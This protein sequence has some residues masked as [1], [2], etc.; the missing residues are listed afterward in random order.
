MIKQL[1]TFAMMLPLIT[2]LSCKQENNTMNLEATKLFQEN[3]NYPYMAS[4]KR[5]AVILDNMNKL[6]KRMTKN[7]VI[8]LM[9]H[10]DEFNLTYKF[11]RSK[12]EDVIGFSLVYLLRRNA[13]S[14]NAI[15]KN[16]QLLRIHFDNS[17]KLLWAYSSG[18]KGFNVIK[19]E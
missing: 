10:P 9:T 19:K 7:Q 17:E 18:I 3:I 1:T 5:K 14:G 13:K 6:E 4:E 16:E 2:L 11:K 15:E 8:Q 12:P